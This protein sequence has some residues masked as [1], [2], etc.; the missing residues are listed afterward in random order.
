MVAAICTPDKLDKK[1]LNFI[2]NE[3]IRSH[4]NSHTTLIIHP[5]IQIPQVQKEY[6]YKVLSRAEEPI[7]RF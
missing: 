7:L 5:T 2:K 4:K 3:I 6:I 1:R